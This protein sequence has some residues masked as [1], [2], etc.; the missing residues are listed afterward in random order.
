MNNKLDTLVLLETH[1]E[2]DLMNPMK[3]YFNQISNREN[4]TGR[5]KS[6]I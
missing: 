3:Y 2:Y 1:T 5:A 4:V 6:G